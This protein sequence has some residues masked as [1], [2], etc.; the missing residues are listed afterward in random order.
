[1]KTFLESRQ[2]DWTKSETQTDRQ[3][4][5]VYGNKIRTKRRRLKEPATGLGR[6]TKEQI[7]SE[8][9]DSPEIP[10]RGGD[11]RR[12]WPAFGPK[13]RWSLRED[14]ESRIKYR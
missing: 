8:S 9:N 12:T 11:I 7:E 14:F 6:I 3:T 1:M 5:V 2:E 10:D 4:R 13:E